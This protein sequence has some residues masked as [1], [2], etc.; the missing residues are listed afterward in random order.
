MV[1]RQHNFCLTPKHQLFA[2]IICFFIYFSSV[3]RTCSPGVV[4]GSS[5]AF[6]NDKKT[7]CWA[8][9]H[10]DQVSFPPR[11]EHCLPHQG[12]LPYLEGLPSIGL[13]KPN[14]SIRNISICGRYYVR[15]VWE[16]LRLIQVTL[17][18]Q[19]IFLQGW[20][21]LLLKV[22]CALNKWDARLLVSFS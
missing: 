13:K 8:S 18:L 20:S 15:E 19:T 4:Y 3:S 9:V 21:I 11:K 7:L 12:L 5:N 1:R 14:L 2:P 17:N 6:K 10:C 22:F 16:G